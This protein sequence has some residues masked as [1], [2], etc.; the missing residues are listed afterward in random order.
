MEWN[1]GTSYYYTL[2]RDGE[3]CRTI[4][5]GVGI[6]RPDWL[7]RGGANYLGQVYIDGFLCNAWEKLQFVWYYED[8]VSKRPVRWDFF[9]GNNFT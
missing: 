8:V 4:E 2:G 9:D 7:T 3:T 6:P 5:F 1:N